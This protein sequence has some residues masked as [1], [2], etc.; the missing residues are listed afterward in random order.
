MTEKELNAAREIHNKIKRLQNKL[1][2]LRET[3]GVSS[4]DLFATPVQG[5]AGP[6]SAGQV[7]AELTQEIS[8]L[9][10]KWE[11]EREI[12]RRELTKA[13][14]DELGRKLLILRY[15][16]CLPWWLVATSIGYSK[17]HTFLLHRKALKNII[18]HNSL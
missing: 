17:P 8:A 5:G 6:I 14:L 12:I 15:V 9:I 4:P 11:I 1:D 3:G 7:A 13:P 18:P 16:D 10:K 2:D